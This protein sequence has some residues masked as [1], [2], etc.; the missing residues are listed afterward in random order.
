MKLYNWS[1]ST[2]CPVISPLEPGSVVTM[3]LVYLRS[4][5]S[6]LAF[7]VMGAMFKDSLITPHF[8][9]D[10]LVIFSFLCECPVGF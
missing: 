5:S 7:N 10:I 8:G 6:K 1:L 3:C 2:T 9:Q 4:K